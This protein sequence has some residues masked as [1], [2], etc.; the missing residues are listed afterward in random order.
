MEPPSGMYALSPATCIDMADE[1]QRYWS[2]L[3]GG[4]IDNETV[5]WAD[6]HLTERGIQDALA[7][8]AFWKE[9]LRVAKIPAPQKY[10]TSPLHRCCATA[11]GS[12]SGLDLP[13]QYPFIP[14]I[15]ELLRETNGEH[16]CDRR[17]A[18]SYIHSEFPDYTFEA[19]FTENDELWKADER[20][21]DAA[22]TL[23]LHK[24]LEEIFADDDSTFISI[25]NHSGS[26]AAM[27]RAISH[28]PFPL[29]TGGAMAVL[30][31]VKK[32]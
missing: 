23:R 24:A 3:E 30:V 4:P 9:A 20:E 18:A 13:K 22:Q 19:G 1:P 5:F 15:R 26:I 28:R 12:F 21:T 16:T 31:E 29:P 32:R 7:V 17:S 14:Q 25:T 6:A 27:L 11:K 2:K 8:N 10:Y